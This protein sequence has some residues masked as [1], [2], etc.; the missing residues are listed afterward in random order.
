[1][2]PFLQVVGCSAAE[3]QAVLG[4]QG[5]VFS[6]VSTGSASALP[7]GTPPGGGP[8][9]VR[10]AATQRVVQHRPTSGHGRQCTH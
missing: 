5:D 10:V 8:R 7:G 2:G 6:C 9:E 4:A 3:V 1:M